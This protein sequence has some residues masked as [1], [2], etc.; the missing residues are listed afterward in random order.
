MATDDAQLI[1][2][3]NG[4]TYSVP[5]EL[6]ELIESARRGEIESSYVAEVAEEMA[7]DEKVLIL[8]PIA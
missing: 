2:A 4:K 7:R 5:R 8:S 3:P 6:V 1:T